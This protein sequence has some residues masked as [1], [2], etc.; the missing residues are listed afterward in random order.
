MNLANIS[1]TLHHTVRSNPPKNF[2]RGQGHQLKYLK[3]GNSSS[4]Q[5]GTQSK[6]G[7][8]SYHLCKKTRTEIFLCK[9]CQN[10]FCSDHKNPKMAYLTLSKI[11][12]TKEP[13]KSELE[14]EFRREDAHPDYPYTRFKVEELKRNEKERDEKMWDVLNKLKR[15][16]S[17]GPLENQG[18]S[19]STHSDSKISKIGNR[20]SRHKRKLVI[21]IICILV[22]IVIYLLVLKS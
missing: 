22:I 19:L 9:Y 21:G 20:I 11:L 13:L 8:C 16:S 1:K 4:Y 10:Y 17:K 18:K 12:Q 15:I 2:Q 5:M 14:K 3:Q 6:I 7:R